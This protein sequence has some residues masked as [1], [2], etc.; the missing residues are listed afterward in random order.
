[1]RHEF[2]V[3]LEQGII[4]EKQLTLD[5]DKVFRSTA[6]QANNLLVWLSV[7]MR[8]KFMQFC[9]I[10]IGASL[11]PHSIRKE[12]KAWSFLKSSARIREE[13]Q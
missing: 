13:E 6:I 9:T 12:K 10:A 4:A 2:A 11:D 5:M 3:T 7:Y 1:M 8:Y